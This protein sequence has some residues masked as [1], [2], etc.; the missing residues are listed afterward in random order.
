MGKLG[1]P[2]LLLGRGA[3][4]LARLTQLLRELK[5]TGVA[6]LLAEQNHQVALR[7]AERAAF[8]EKGR[9]VDE[10]PADRARGSEVLHR[11]LGV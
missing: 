1:S 9:V 7:T 8:M 2:A 3:V 5:Q 11:I 10:L 4:A 6:I